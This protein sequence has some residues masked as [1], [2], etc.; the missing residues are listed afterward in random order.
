MS[1]WMF[2]K[3]VH[4]P[5]EVL[6]R[7][8]DERRLQSSTILVLF[9]GLVG[10]LA[11]PVA[12]ANEIGQPS[13]L[14]MGFEP[15]SITSAQD[16]T[17]ST[18]GHIQRINNHRPITLSVDDG[19]SSLPYEGEISISPNSLQVA[20]PDLQAYYL[21]QIFQV[22]IKVSPQTPPGTYKVWVKADDGITWESNMFFLTVEGGR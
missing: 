8:L 10:L 14:G 4:Y 17:V 1:R 21:E 12:R 19:S 16:G 2:T 18:S 7:G 6:M 22:T 15:R 9:I 5:W 20:E 13:V 3:V 11:V